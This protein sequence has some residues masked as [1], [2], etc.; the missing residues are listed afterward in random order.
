MVTTALA[1]VGPAETVPPSLAAL[2]RRCPRRLLGSGRH[3]GRRL[4]AFPGNAAHGAPKEEPVHDRAIPVLTARVEALCYGDGL[5]R[6]HGSCRG[7]A[8][9][10]V[11]GR[12][13]GG[14]GPRAHV[15]DR[16]APSARPRGLRR[17]RARRWL[18]RGRHG[19]GGCCGRCAMGRTHRSIVQGCVLGLQARERDAWRRGGGG[20]GGHDWCHSRRARVVAGEGGRVGAAAPTARAYLPGTRA[21]AASRGRRRRARGRRRTGGPARGGACTPCPWHEA[22]RKEGCVHGAGPWAP[23]A[24]GRSAVGSASSAHRVTRGPWPA[25]PGPSAPPRGGSPEAAHPR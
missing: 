17:V 23:A 1:N 18:A 16:P 25:R 12:L 11:G 3:G 15:R 14:G 22:A 21:H 2:P 9:G 4:Q 10:G 5:T 24:D 20:G 13:R 6:G 8:V 7:L 19:G